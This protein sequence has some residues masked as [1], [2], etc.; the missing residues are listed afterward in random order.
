MYALGEGRAV[1]ELGALLYITCT[2]HA[3]THAGRQASCARAAG[4]SVAGHVHRASC[5]R[6]CCSQ[7]V[8]ARE[9]ER[10]RSPHSGGGG[11]GGVFGVGLE[12]S[13]ISWS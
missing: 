13:W 12:L 4:R 6:A 9:R 2:A 5:W 11:G 3:R 7:I 8:R 10:E 1:V